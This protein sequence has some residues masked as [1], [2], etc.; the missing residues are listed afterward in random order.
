MGLGREVRVWGYGMGLGL[1]C[2]VTVR[3]RVWCQTPPRSR[4]TDE[5]TPLKRQRTIE[6]QGLQSRHRLERG[7][8]GFGSL[9]PQP[10]VCV[11]ADSGE[12]ER[13]DVVVRPN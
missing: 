11:H 7:R 4:H 13:C 12:N 3:V 5:Q 6:V 8:E 10:V 2:G 9:R 1:G